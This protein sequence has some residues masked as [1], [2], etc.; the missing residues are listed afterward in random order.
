LPSAFGLAPLD[1]RI[2]E[3]GTLPYLAAM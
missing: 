2:L 1:R 3:T